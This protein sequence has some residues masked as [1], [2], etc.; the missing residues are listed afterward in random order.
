MGITE[1]DVVICGGGPGGSACAMG[2]A[3]TNIKVAVIEKST[4]PREKVCGDGMAPYIAKALN[5]M[6]PAFLDAF[7]DFQERMP[8][9]HIRLVS[10]NGVSACMPLPE[11]W[12][13]SKRFDFDNFLF[14]QASALPNVHFFT[15]EQIT[16]VQ[17]TETEVRVKTNRNRIFTAK[18][19]IGCDGAS[20]I[21]RRKLTTYKLDASHHCAAV[22]AYYSGVKFLEPDTFE[23]HLIPKYPWGYFWIFP[24]SEGHANV[25]F[26]VFTEDIR[27]QNL[28]LREVFHEVIQETASLR[29]RFSDAILLSEVKGWGIPLGYGRHAI[30]GNRFM[31]VGDAASIADPLTGEGI[32]QAIVTGRIAANHAKLCFS[33]HDFSA[34]MMKAYDKEMHQ[35]WGK[36]NRKRKSFAKLIGKYHWLPD[37]LVAAISSGSA[38]RR[39]A[40]FFIRKSAN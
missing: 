9:N 32:G 5:K 24:S 15:D 29:E 23:F 39:I 28:N 14:E 31:L 19:I 22:R 27:Q 36:Q 2:F 37:T 26:G 10:Y 16:E 21:V 7:N 1:F 6:S 12:F 30:S 40:M 3:G 25:G 11:P 34:E 18:L 33:K 20:S 35:K 17:S 8:I 13:V 4:F 38:L